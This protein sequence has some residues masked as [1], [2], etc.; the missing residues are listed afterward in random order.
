[1]SLLQIIDKLFQN[2]NLGKRQL[3]STFENYKITNKNKKA[4]ENAKKVC[5]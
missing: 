3:N 5:Q 1:M 4:Y 2:N